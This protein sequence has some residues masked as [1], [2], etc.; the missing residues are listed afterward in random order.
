MSDI[1]NYFEYISKKL[2]ENTA[3]PSIVCLNKI[4]NRITFEIKNR[5]LFWTFNARNDE[6]TWKHGKK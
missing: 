1:Q 2:G 3:N 6:I 4:E 5:V